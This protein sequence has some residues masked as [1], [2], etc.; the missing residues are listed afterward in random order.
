MIRVNNSN[1]DM[2]ENFFIFTDNLIINESFINSDCF[3]EDIGMN[4]KIRLEKKRMINRYMS[5]N[6]ISWDSKIKRTNVLYTNLGRP[7]L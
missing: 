1:L 4:E 2:D 5:F 3:S 6:I 7:Y